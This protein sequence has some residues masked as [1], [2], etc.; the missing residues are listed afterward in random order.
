MGF[1]FLSVASVLVFGVGCGA[2][3][4]DDLSPPTL[5]TL[6][7]TDTAEGAETGTPIDTGDIGDTGPP[8]P[9]DLDGDGYSVA[10][11]DCDDAD[12]TRFPGNDER[13]DGLDNDCD[14][15]VDA[16][17]PVDGVLVYADF[18]MDSW[19]VA[20]HTEIR[21]GITVGFS[22]FSGDCDDTDDAISPSAIEVC[23][24]VDNDCDGITDADALAGSIFYRDA[25]SDGYGDPDSLVKA[26][27][28]PFGFVDNALD[29]LD[30]N[31]SVSPDGTESCNG[32]DDD[33]DGVIDNGYTAALWFRD[34]DGDG[35]GDPAKATLSCFPP[36]G[37]V[38]VGGDCDDS[39]AEI[40]GDMLELCD[41]KDNDC[42]GVVDE[43]LSD[44]VFYRDLDGDGYGTMSDEIIDCAPVE[45]YVVDGT[46]CDDVDE[47]IRPG[48]VE[49][50]NG[51]DDNC[52][53]VIDE[54][55]PLDPY[56]LD[57]DDDGYGAG[58][59]QLACS[60][61]V[62]HVL[63]GSDCDDADPLVNP[64]IY[65]DCENDR[66]DDCDGAID[67]GPDSTFYR[68]FDGDGFGDASL[69]M[70]E[71]APPPGWV[72]DDTDC[73]DSDAG[74]YPEHREN[75]SDGLDNDCDGLDDDEDPDCDCPDHGF[76]EDEDLGTTTGDAVA[77]G[78]TVTEDDTYTFGECG[79]SGAKDRFF[80]FEAPEDGCYTFDTE[81]SGYDT[82][83][84]V[85]DACEGTS[86]DCDD[87]GGSGVLSIIETP[88]AEGD[89]VFVVVDGYSVSSSGE[90]TLNINYEAAVSS[91]AGGILAYDEDLGDGLGD[92]I[93]SGDSL[94]M[95]D[96]YDGS[97]GSS[98]GVDVAFLWEAP[99]DGCY[100][101]DTDGSSYD[102]VLRVFNAEIGGGGVIC[103][104]SGSG[105]SE[106]ACDDDGGLGVSSRLS[107]TVSGGAQY[108]IVVDGFGSSS[109]GSYVLS[110][111]EC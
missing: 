68:D 28:R 76:V 58:D 98:A 49:D 81:G 45:G 55:W 34:G 18:D 12:P 61:P 87:D 96:D 94:G 69:T 80:R 59:A 20:S 102:T 43:D 19:G 44:M 50:C 33:C 111:N 74:T 35:H 109:V 60:A 106:L 31:A 73:D 77:S 41:L 79:S 4:K 91:E 9:V 63:D 110:I 6:P 22:R 97:C 15:A 57:A 27:S 53:G 65:A 52:D 93:A 24:G 78:S 38:A 26:C 39:D 75:C 40:H 86:I 67:E 29:C 42:D 11:G 72:W 8:V 100:E 107:R 46:D 54:T 56:Y 14:G 84:R 95:G 99:D 71:C 89:Q 101:I 48:R 66:D 7:D 25:D 70:V 83:L 2:A 10:A 32:V 23:D 62:G 51:I 3:L 104:G 1:G 103:G 85:L 17:N 36:S 16:P 82:L 108:I 47:E 30:S 105:P 92:A 88:L 13:C 21:C 5:S 64:G 90:Y 37:F